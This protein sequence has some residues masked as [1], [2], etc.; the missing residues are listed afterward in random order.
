MADNSDFSIP[1]EMAPDDDEFDPLDDLEQDDLV[2]VHTLRIIFVRNRQN[3]NGENEVHSTD[4]TFGIYR[5][6]PVGM[7]REIMLNYAERYVGKWREPGGSGLM[8][9]WDFE[10]IQ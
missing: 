4:Y 3:M 5:A 9:D 2:F 7:L 8:W 10:V 1:P 6:I